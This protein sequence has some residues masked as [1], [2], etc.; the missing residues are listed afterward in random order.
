MK[1]YLLGLACALTTTAALAQTT[2]DTRL[3]EL[4]GRPRTPQPELAGPGL[5]PARRGP[6]LRLPAKRIT[7][8]WNSATQQ[9]QAP[10]H[11]TTSYTADGQPSL[12]VIA[13]SA[14]QQLQA[15]LTYAY[16]ATGR[17]TLSLGE[18]WTGSAWQNDKRTTWTYDA[19]GNFTSTLDQQWVAGAWQNVSQL[20]NTY[21]SRNNRTSY[22]GQNWV[23]GAW[24]NS[25]GARSAYTYNA[26]G[27]IVQ[28]VEETLDTFLNTYSSRGRS[29]YTYPT[30]TSSLYSQVEYQEL[31]AGAYV[32]NYRLQRTHDAQ[33]RITYYETQTW[34]GTAWGPS[35]RGNYVYGPQ[36]GDV[37]E[38]AEYYS[39]G[40]WVNSSR[41]TFLNDAYGNLSKYESE[42]WQ[43]GAWIISYGYRYLRKY[44]PNGDIDRQVEQM[45]TSLGKAYENNRKDSFSDFQSITLGVQANAALA[46]Q[47]QLYPNPTTGTVTLKLGELKEQAP[48]R[49]EVVNSLGQVVQRLVLQPRQGHTV[50]DLSAQPSGLYTVQL[51]TA[52][53]LVVK[54]VVRQ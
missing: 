5:A 52:A 14:T 10:M 38:T 29:I 39:F 6:A 21:D 37:Q 15:R 25:F 7:Y 53:G 18:K 43:N 41:Y 2:P 46:A 45:V 3:Q 33:Q 48:V 22:L 13:D 1:H 35:T 23:N 32:S 50:L 40:S 31:E 47:T 12:V 11:H 28:T 36:P 51:H 27:Q 30:P 9:W 20:L 8:D 54:K 34:N 24:V 19:Q 44:N 49:V 16:N 17:Q 26:T 42:T 4:L